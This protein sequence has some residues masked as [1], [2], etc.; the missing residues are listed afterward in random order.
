MAAAVNHNNGSL[1]TNTYATPLVTNIA[2]ADST[3]VL[4]WS[5]SCAIPDSGTDLAHSV[6]SFGRVKSSDVIHSLIFASTALTAGAISL[7]LFLPNTVT[8][9]ATNSDHLFAT[10]INCASAVVPTEELYTNLALTNAGKRVW[11]MLG[12]A[13]DPVLVYDIAGYSTTA[14]TAAGTL[15]CRCVFAPS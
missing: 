15:F 7:G 1:T 2:G 14:A 4:N 12:F 10:S 6:Y 8:V 13:S 9:A 5:A 11:E 3:G